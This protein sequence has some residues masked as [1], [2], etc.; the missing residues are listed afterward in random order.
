[1]ESYHPV[2]HEVREDLVR[3]VISER[4]RE[5]E[6]ACRPLYLALGHV[7]F[8]ERVQRVD[9]PEDDALDGAHELRVD[10][11]P[12]WVGMHRRTGEY[13]WRWESRW[14]ADPERFAR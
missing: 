7:A 12:V 5:I 3:Q 9:R 6:R 2:P 13:S 10:D 11:V 14:I 4:L 1:M 8:I